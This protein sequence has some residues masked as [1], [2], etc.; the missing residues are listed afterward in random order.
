MTLA[1]VPERRVLLHLL[2]GHR[3]HAV[4]LVVYMLADQVDS[5][6][7]GEAGEEGYLSC[8]WADQAAPEV[9]ALFASPGESVKALRRTYDVGV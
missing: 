9:I 3:Q 5:A 8:P 1:S 7:K 4:S 2:D 6:C